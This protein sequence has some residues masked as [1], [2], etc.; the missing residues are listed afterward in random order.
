MLVPYPKLRPTEAEHD[1]E[2]NTLSENSRRADN[3]DL[4]A[5]RVFVAEREST[6]VNTPEKAT[7]CALSAVPQRHGQSPATQLNI[8]TINRRWTFLRHHLIPSLCD[9]EI[10]VKY[11][12]VIAGM[13]R[14]MDAGLVRGKKTTRSRPVRRH[15]RTVDRH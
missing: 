12:H 3:S 4:R 2:V 5:F 7:F 6:L 8:A 13:R 11:R 15:H 14:K 9:P 1:Y 10:E